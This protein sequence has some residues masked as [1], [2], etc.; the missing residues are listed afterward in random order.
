[1]KYSPE[2]EQEIQVARGVLEIWLND[3]HRQEVL[4]RVL[5]TIE[6]P[7]D[8]V[9]DGMVAIISLPA[10]DAV[11]LAKGIRLILGLLVTCAR[12]GASPGVDTSLN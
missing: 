7:L 9:D 5:R 8:K 3:P 4:E 10:P 1:M 11:I 2:V 12:M 6:K